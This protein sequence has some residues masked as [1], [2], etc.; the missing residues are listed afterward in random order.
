MIYLYFMFV[1]FKVV[2]GEV[3]YLDERQVDDLQNHVDGEFISVWKHDSENIERGANT[4]SSNDVRTIVTAGIGLHLRMDAGN[5][6]FLD[7]N[8]GVRGEILNDAFIAERVDPED[9]QMLT[10]EGLQVQN[11]RGNTVTF[12]KTDVGITVNDVAL[13]QD[14]QQLSDGKIVYTLE[15]NLFDFREKL[16]EAYRNKPKNDGFQYRGAFGEPI[17]F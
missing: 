12:K 14:P 6:L 15:R 16:E 17:M 10:E 2:A 11:M 3:P 4:R 7:A 5:P 8:E 9:P 13:I 1:V